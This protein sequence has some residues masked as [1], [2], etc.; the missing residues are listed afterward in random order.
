MRRRMGALLVGVALAM[1]LVVAGPSSASADESAPRE[2]LG[3]IVL[4]SSVAVSNRSI[5]GTMSRMGADVAGDRMLG[6]RIGVVDFEAP[7]T[8]AEAA[9]IA[10]AVRARP[11]VVAVDLNVRV[12]PVAD[13]VIPN[14]PYFPQQWDM[15]DG[16][17]PTDYGT[18][19]AG[20]WGVTRGAP[21][22]VVGV[23]DT[24]S[25][26]HPDLEGTT[27]PGFDFISDIPT[28]RDGDRWDPDPSDEG[29]WCP[30][31]N[32]PSNWHGTHVA[33]TINAVQ[34]NAIGITG[35]APGVKVQHLRALGECGGSLADILAAVTW[36]SGGDPTGTFGTPGVNP[37]VNPTPAS[38]L[39]LSL[40]GSANCGVIAQQIFDA[41]RARGT[42]VVVAAGNEGT[43]VST[44]WP[45]N[46]QRVINVTSGTRSG[47]L[48]SFSNFGTSIGE[49]A[50]TA[51]GSGIWS[52]SNTGTTT[53]ASPTYTVM[54][55]TSMATPHV[56]AAAALLYS[57][58]VT[59]PDDVEAALKGSVTPFPSSSC[60]VVRCGAG[61]LDV[62]K[63]SRYQPITNPA[64]P[65][66]VTAVAGDA[67]AS[68]SW[69]VPAETGGSP[70]VSAKATASPGGQSCTTAETSCVITGLTN[71]A[72]YTVAVTVTNAS[73]LV[74]PAAV[75]PAFTPK[76]PAT[77]P[78]R[79]SDFTQ[80]RFTKSARTYAVTV[81]WQPP[82]DDGGSPV[83]GYLAR[84][85]TGGRWNAWTD[86]TRASA[87]MTSLRPG[88][89]YTVQVRA[90][91]DVG[92]GP[93]VGWA[94][95]TPRR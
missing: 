71:G 7:M 32:A 55:G 87:R 53:P 93:R 21:T 37:G 31:D 27:V 40:G 41:A 56:S 91:N 25:T 44:S 46:C 69:V 38:V 50:L 57:L 89:T 51:P 12:Y 10:A 73:G 47:A 19:A 65:T 30:D 75:S 70:L 14:D 43:S 15:W 18:R 58:G 76:T 33:G 29:D 34:D 72:A 94:F 77:V 2:V 81:R 9:P 28:A 84:F 17:G 63:L 45:A 49:I 35:L 92:P 42:T 26:V 90:V 83:T 68:V 1:G 85:G 59:R 4:K 20:I 86:L 23:I 60:D 74:S 95:T 52:T 61:L 16:G 62:S 66:S 6:A 3:L 8:A 79:V 78:G 64:A 48:S 13:P 88:T 39:N 36:G 54:S 11:D 22:V 24:G 80:G 82:A 67:S 5:E